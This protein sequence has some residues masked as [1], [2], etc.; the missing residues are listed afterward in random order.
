MKCEPPAQ[1]SEVPQLLR[2]L[3]R[4]VNFES[5]EDVVR[6]GPTVDDYRRI[7][8]R[9]SDALTPRPGEPSDPLEYWWA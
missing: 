9:M 7:V 8:R 2:R 1:Q 4:G 6:D 3:S 5:K